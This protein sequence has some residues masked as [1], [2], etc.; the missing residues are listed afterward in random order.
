MTDAEIK[1]VADAVRGLLDERDV[2]LRMELASLRGTLEEMQTEAQDLRSKMAVLPSTMHAATL[3][4]V[5]AV[6][7][8]LAAALPGAVQSAAERHLERML[9]TRAMPT[10]EATS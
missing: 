6:V 2:A 7:T 5:K 4:T 8:P 1:S 9:T 3:A 10:S